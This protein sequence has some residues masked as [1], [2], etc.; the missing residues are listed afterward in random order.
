MTAGP[1]PEASFWN[2]FDLLFLLALAFS[3]IPG[4]GWLG[5]LQALPSLFAVAAGG[6][7]Y[8]S[9]TGQILV[10]YW[11]PEAYLGF[12]GR[13]GAFDS[14]GVRR[15]TPRDRPGQILVK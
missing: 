9:N 14:T 11:P 6:L 10:K 3:L 5:L 2:I 4:C 13:F 1:P 15:R 12:E 7:K 8:W